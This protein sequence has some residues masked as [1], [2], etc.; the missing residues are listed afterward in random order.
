[1]GVLRL[2]HT[3]RKTAGGDIY[4]FASKLWD[5]PTRGQDFLQLRDR[6]DDTFDIER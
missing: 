3:R 5:I 4:N 6:L 1:M 2:S